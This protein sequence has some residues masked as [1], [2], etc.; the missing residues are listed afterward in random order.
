MRDHVGAP[1]RSGGWPSGVGGALVAA[2]LIALAAALC[3][4]APASAATITD[5]PL[6]FS[7]D[8]SGST[9][10]PLWNPD[11][12]AVDNQSGA[13][14]VSNG[15]APGSPRPGFVSKF[16]PDGTPADFAA[17]DT[18][19]IF[20]PGSGFGFTLGLAVDN[21]GGPYKGRL[22]VSQ[23]NSGAL[24]AFAADGSHEWTLIPSPIS[25]LFFAPCDAAVD[26]SG[27][28]WLGEVIF[29]QD[30][31]K[32]DNTGSPP[33][34]TP[35]D[36][37]PLLSADTSCKFD[38]DSAGNLYVRYGGG[39]QKYVG[40]SFDS[41]LD[42]SATDVYANQSTTLPTPATAA[43]VF[44][45]S[46]GDF[47]EYSPAG[48]LLGT[49]GGEYVDASF[50]FASIAY[51]PALDRVYVLQAAPGSGTDPVPVV[52]VFGPPTSGAVPDVT[53]GAPSGVG[54]ATAH[55]SG[56]VEPNGV[57]S[58]YH[59][60][61]RRPDTSWAAAADPTAPP[62]FAGS[63]PSQA[64]AGGAGPTAV[65]F[66]LDTLRGDTSYEVRL[67]TVN[68]ADGLRS[69]SAA[70]TF[71][72]LK[73]TE[74]P[75]VTID[76]VEEEPTSPCATGITA[77]SACVSGTVNPEGDT[78]DWRVQVQR[79]CE[80]AFS[81]E[82]L[83]SIEHRAISPIPV[84]YDLKGLLPSERYCVRIRAE[85]SA[86]KTIK[87]ESPEPPVEFT[88]LPIPP[89]QVVTA[90]AA[91]R[92]DTTA[93]L[94]GY[95][96]PEG[97]TLTYRFEYREDGGET[98][99]PL[100]DQHNTSEARQPVLLAEELTELSPA[101]TYS[102]RFVAENAAE[103]DPEGEPGV[104]AVVV[105]EVKTF[106]TRT[107]AEIE[108]VDPSP[109]SCPNEEVRVNRG[110]AYL[111]DCRGFELVNKPDKGNQNVDAFLATGTPPMRA[112]GERAV[113]SVAGG[114]PGGN[115]GFGAAF[116][117]RRT[118]Q[119]EAAPNGWESKGLVPPAA[120]QLEAEDGSYALGAVTPDFTKFIFSTGSEIAGCGH[121]LV[122]LDEDQ[123]QE[124]LGGRYDYAQCP[125][126]ME[127][128]DDAAHV[129][130]VNNTSALSPPGEAK[131]Q[132]IGT[133]PPQT[134]GLLPDGY[135]P[136]CG[137]NPEGG[138]GGPSPGGGVS[139]QWH[140][141]YDLMATTDAS[142]VYFAV[143]PNGECEGF[144]PWWLLE[145][146][147]SSGQTLEVAPPDL[148]NA[149]IRATPDGR[150][151]YFVSALKLDRE[152]RDTNSHVDVYRWDE[153]ADGLSG[154]ATCL[155]CAVENEAGEAIT[156]A[157]LYVSNGA[158]AP[159]M[160]SDDFSH[161]YFESESKLT[162]QAT[163]GKGKGN[164]YVLAGGRVRFV[165]D[166]N[167][168]DTLDYSTTA[169]S[170]DGNVLVFET[171][172]NGNHELTADGLAASC[173]SPTTGAPGPC[174]ELFRYDDRD[175]SL[176]CVS[177]LRG[178][179]TTSSV[180]AARRTDVTRGDFS[181][182]AD[183][184]VLAFVTAQ[185]LVPRDV[186]N[187]LDLYE[188][189]AGVQHLITDGV[190]DFGQTG[191]AALRVL[192]T[193]AA[194]RDILFTVD[195]PGL[196]GFERDGFSNLYDAREEGGF[197]PPPAPVHCSEESCQG[198]LQAA[199]PL[200]QPGSATIVGRGNVEEGKGK[201]RCSKG[202][203]RRHGRCVKPRRRK[204]HKARHRRHRRTA[205]ANQGR[206]R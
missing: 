196:T 16:H 88:T 25:A 145:R 27:Y 147:R 106:T 109:G 82:A 198:P 58:H 141:G 22:Y 24:Y 151:A 34:P 101:T 178:G 205:R 179:L 36:S 9:A 47:Q 73:A 190:G 170:G 138:F 86:G 187:G 37:I 93:R 192:A 77:E 75:A 116:L 19:S 155:T 182:S 40:G 123:H 159:A 14:Y 20:G 12:I 125:Y 83:G 124:A 115:T 173:P 118:G 203:V 33:S 38:F 183:G 91:P 80:G 53:A 140:P 94:N 95:A 136:E 44:T 152:G 60:E 7:F 71:K 168:G 29:S 130:R 204:H 98:W 201:P 41:T 23:S 70:D 72:T 110:F 31:W 51:D 137:L 149:M 200:E 143:A 163:P 184:E 57:D 54:V 103:P 48:G 64:L 39:I 162:P 63:S 18:S 158:A 78:A 6:L 32:Y 129:L 66:D 135:E 194:G 176:E 15:R 121:S 43:H 160:V 186:N 154:S 17:A 161:L 79:N 90:F 150:S 114:A 188:W 84:S 3:L 202:R 199:P 195:R 156:D 35:L 167:N 206:A 81:D 87:P 153:A 191:G 105:G 85:N 148:H 67:V 157:N 30:V 193:G 11:T 10:G 61:W 4:A 126:D 100:P 119:S 55:F 62:R 132:D 102:Y 128:S 174:R 99:I 21:S 120:E 69:V 180:G 96:N 146:D 97:E 8:G 197:E 65:S 169:L 49:Y 59:F 164:L 131:L 108:A 127:L 50:G 165:A 52:A 113:W 104:T 139:H 42:P 46:S 177:C 92:T 2:C 142:R 13:V 28:P 89:D 166:T 68:D 111:P 107:S 1:A 172:E 171:A 122:R 189:R 175:R 26:P 185:A 56:T 45:L 134:V 74:P 76:P 5:R 117:A 144:H 181:L 112:D 133:D